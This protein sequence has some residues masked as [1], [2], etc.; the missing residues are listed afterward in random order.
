MDSRM[1]VQIAQEHIADLRRTAAARRRGREVVEESRGASVIALRV[2]GPD[3]VAELE[4]LAALDSAQPLSGEALVALVDGRLVAAIAL[5]DGRII[6]DPLVAT[7]EA[8]ELLQTRAAQLAVPRRRP[9][10]RLRPRIA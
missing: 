9:R 4:W 8:R 3:E 7:S 10:W 5:G 2:A 6:A 1:T